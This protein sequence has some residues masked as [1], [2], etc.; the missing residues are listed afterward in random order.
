MLSL[1]NTVRQIISEMNDWSDA[2][3]EPS[4]M[5]T[6][7]RKPLEHVA[8][9]RVAQDSAVQLLGPLEQLRPALDAKLLAVN[10]L[11]AALA[12]LAS[13]QSAEGDPSAD[14]Q[15]EELTT[16]ESESAADQSLPMQGDFLSDL[17]NRSLPRPNY[18]AQEI[19]RRN[20]KTRRPAPGTNPRA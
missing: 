6:V 9:A 5:N 1:R 17:V 12:L 8:R 15:P 20:W 16:A 14:Q 4:R 2:P 7:L 11:E 18:S 10:E 3:V 13:G 19:C